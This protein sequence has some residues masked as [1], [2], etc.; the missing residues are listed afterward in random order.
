[1]NYADNPAARK[2]L[3]GIR[4]FLKAQPPSSLHQ[5]AMVM[6]AGVHVADLLTAEERAQTVKA[7]AAAQRPD[8]G[9]SLASL[10]DNCDD[11]HRQTEAGR[12]ARADKGHGAEFLIFVGSDKV[13]KSSLASDGYATGL[14]VYV[15]RQAGVPADDAR[16]RRGVAWLKGHQ[17]ESGRWFT[18]SE[19]WHTQ[20][21]IANAGNAH[22]VFAP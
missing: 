9:W 7:L 5:K 10:V 20:N 12:N 22:A 4:K 15:L 2:G 21:R 6:W 8:G 14:T 1:E 13:Y 18:P 17:R 11:P 19:A 3:A 16:M